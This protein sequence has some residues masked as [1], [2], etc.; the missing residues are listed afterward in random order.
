[1]LISTV[2]HD[3]AAVFIP[4]LGRWVYED[5]E[6]N[7]EYL[8]DGA[9]Q[10]LAPTDLLALTSAGSARRLRA[11]K[12]PGPSFDPEVYVAGDTYTNYSNGF[13]IMGSQLNNRVAGVV[14]PGV[15]SWPMRYVQIDVPQLLQYSP[16]NDPVRYDRVAAAVA[17][18][19][20]GVVVQGLQVQDSVYVVQLSSTFPNHQHF[21][22][23]LN[24]GEWENVAE[25]DVLPVGQ[26]RM[27]YRSVDSVGDASGTTVLDVWVPRAA[28]F[29]EAGVPGGVRR[30]ARFCI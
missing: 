27:E 29:I 16:W 15:G 20:L 28:E 7:E 9:G 8:L 23:R 11:A 21:E 6:W 5:P 22:R 25:V 26:C 4:E 10:P 19:T 14:V 30:Q 18:P 2:G 17:F 3:P 1:M 24:G 13:L 12:L